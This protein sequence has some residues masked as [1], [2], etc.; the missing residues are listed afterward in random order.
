[1]SEPQ[2]TSPQKQGGPQPVEQEM[3]LDTRLLSD[4]VI[5]LNIS[6]KNVAIYPPG[7][8]QITRS[9]ERAYDVLLKLFAIRSEMTLGVA[10]DTLFVGQNYLDRKNPVYRD[11]AL[12][13]N[14]QGV[15]AVTFVSGLD[16]AELERFHR[17]ITTKHQD[18]AAAGGIA[19]VAAA[20][21]IPHIRV[22]PVDYGR[23]HVTEEK[24]LSHGSVATAGE[25]GPGLWGD[26]VSH[27]SA[28]TIAVPGQEDGVALK[29]AE[30]IDPA[31]LARLLNERKLDPS[32][33]LQSYDRIITS[34]VRVSAERKQLT[35]SQSDTLRSL[36]D[37]LKDLHPD[38][39]RQ[40]LSVTFQRTAD[41]S[42]AVTEEIMGGLT[43]NMI[44][45]MLQQANAEGR[46]ISPTLTGLLQK[47]AGAGGAAAGPGVGAPR[48]P[49]G[50]AA[51]SLSPEQFQSLF[52]REQYESYVGSEYDET[53]KRLATRPHGAAAAAAGAFPIDE[54]LASMTDEKL[55]YQ[56]GRVLLG[57]IDED[58]GDE[59]YGEFLKKVISNMSELVKTEQFALLH[60]TYETLR[61]HVRE[62]QSIAIRSMADIALRGFRDPVFIEQ[63]VEGYSFCM[64]RERTRAAGRLLLALGEDALPALFELYARDEAAGGKRQVFDLLCR[65]GGSAVQG[66]LKRLG[67]GR[68][69]FVRNLVMLVRWQGDRS[70]CP[71][72]RPLLKHVDHRV[73][74]EAIAALLRFQD[75]AA[76]PA[77]RAGIRSNDP[78][79]SAQAVSLAGQFRVAGVVNDV[80]GRLKKAIFF[81]SDYRENEETIR[82]LGEI[83]DE[84]AVPELE[85]MARGTWPLYPRSRERMKA[86][87]FESLERY[88]AAAIQGLLAIGEQSNDPRVLRA[89]RK[90]REGANR[91]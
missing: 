55:D 54:Y 65:F 81:E 76:V 8:V 88:P 29:D 35:R 68:P 19:Q 39:R 53:L 17:I 63:L 86:V 49:T 83:G 89:C 12:S 85:R 10:K 43:D 6:R 26:F 15:A 37:L 16:L 56:I 31:E 40:F 62:K 4:A 59:D 80:L 87:L 75:T 57:F 84:A 2:E 14:A 64:S 90:T 32:L 13:L 66:A 24:E 23:F 22:L 47:L 70:V 21:D 91:G 34:H 7:H 50:A 67:D 74:F 72:L 38:L 78:D 30:Q 61:L 60:D 58:I 27:L 33:A 48:P 82:V 25:D 36:N 20:M 73:R 9:I 5:E 11:F 52:T 77:L 46:E 51:A 18:I 1:M 28:G 44:I 42:P 69:A 3:P 45:E 71:Q 79:V 41:A